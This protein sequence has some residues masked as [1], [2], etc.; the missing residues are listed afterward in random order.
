MEMYQISNAV[1]TI[2]PPIEGTV[3]SAAVSRYVEQYNVL[4]RKTAVS[5][6]GL[7]K[8]L[9]EAEKELN[10]DDFDIFCDQVGI[11]GKKATY[12]KL[13]TIGMSVS[14]FDPYLERLPNTWTTLYELAKIAPDQFA[15]IA[16][17]LTPFTTAKEIDEM[18]GDQVAKSN[19]KNLID[20]A[21]T[22]GPME[23]A[24]KKEVYDAINDLKS[25][26]PLSLKPSKV[27]ENE[28]KKFNQTKKAA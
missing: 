22:F 15:R 11:K 4:A 21:I 28:F 13:R 8:T 5:I 25:K 26:Y 6:I 18:L 9:V 10:T 17:D 2:S 16:P 1:M 27:L 23:I 7:A 19:K 14:R 20:L 24:N 12:T 3:I